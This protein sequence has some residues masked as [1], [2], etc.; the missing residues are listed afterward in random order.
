MKRGFTL[1]ELLI[2]IGIIAIL[3][4]ALIVG[5]SP[6]ERFSQARDATREGHVNILYN[7]LISYQVNH[8]GQWGEI[9]MP[10]ELTE[11]C[12]TNLENPNCEENELVN[13]SDLTPSY[14]TQ[15][16]VDPQGG[17]DENGTGY[18]ISQSSIIIVAERA[19]TGFIGIGI[20]EELLNIPDSFQVF[21][22]EENSS[23]LYIDGIEIEPG[24]SETFVLDINKEYTLDKG[25]Y[26]VNA[27]QGGVDISEDMIVISAS[28]SAHDGFGDY[29]ASSQVFK[30]P[31]PANLT[32]EGLTIESGPP[33]EPPPICP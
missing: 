24:N 10:Q 13:L 15:I 12:N 5:L 8:Q 33:P 19:E 4:A 25:G 20:T 2:V 1:I 31:D 27:Y 11:I 14:I 16:P 6:G 9:D 17:I 22:N 30:F 18:F 21:H 29:C 28:P 26:W 23:S 32:D 7:S 3:A